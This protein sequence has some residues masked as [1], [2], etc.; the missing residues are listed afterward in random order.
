MNQ[1]MHKKT[2][3]K[4]KFVRFLESINVGMLFLFNT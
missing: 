3:K 1:Q 2:H 4:Y